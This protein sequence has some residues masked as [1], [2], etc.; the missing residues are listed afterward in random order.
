MITPV[1][2]SLGR[3]NYGGLSKLGAHTPR[4]VLDEAQIERLAGHGV[5][6][7]DIAACLGV[8]DETLRARYQDAIQR[9]RA[10]GRASLR[11]RMYQIAEQERDLKAAK[12]VLI[13]LDLREFGPL[14]P[15]DQPVQLHEHLHVL[16]QESGDRI[17]RQ[18]EAARGSL[19]QA[20]VAR[21]SPGSGARLLTGAPADGGEVRPKPD[22]DEQPAA[23]HDENE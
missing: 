4:V 18:L 11:A 19:G 17:A 14:E 22:A 15:K 21:T 7:A 10:N 5:S 9:G 2:D 1:I 23:Q 8:T 20:E 13:H 3:R 6:V 12:D 16:L